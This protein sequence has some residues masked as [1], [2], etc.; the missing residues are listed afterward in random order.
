MRDRRDAGPGRSA[1]SIP[2][3]VNLILLMVAAVVIELFAV[4]STP[5][6]ENLARTEVVQKAR[7]MMEAA[8]GIR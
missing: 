2:L 3:R 6:L 8:A 7:I 4:V 1:V 5:L